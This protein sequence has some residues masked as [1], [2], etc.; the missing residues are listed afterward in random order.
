MSLTTRRLTAQD[1]AEY[2]QL[3]LT[4]LLTNPDAFLSI[5]EVEVNKS[6]AA[7]ANELAYAIADPCYG[8]YGVIDS[9]KRHQLIAFGQIAKSFLAKQEH[10]A[11]LY[12][13]YVDG[14]Y[15]RQGLAEKLLLEMI[16]AVQ[17]TAPVEMLFVGCNAKNKPALRLYK[18]LGFQ[19]CGI[20]PHSVKWAGEYDDEL[21]LVKVLATPT[22]VVR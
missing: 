9:E 21:Q 18:K 7:F 22:T 16:S 15:R 2:Q 13:L 12:N 4:A 17:T 20:H 19:R 6:T 11:W 3:R 10:V 8:Y 1:A 14:A 5:Y